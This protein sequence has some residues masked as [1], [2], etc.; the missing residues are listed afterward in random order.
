[1]ETLN[2]HSINLSQPHISICQTL[3][4]VALDT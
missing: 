1:M 3:I 4:N 2:M